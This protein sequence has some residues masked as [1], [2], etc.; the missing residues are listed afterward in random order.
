MHK[1]GNQLVCWMG[2][3]CGAQPIPTYCNKEMNIIK[4]QKE[5]LN[6]IKQKKEDDKQVGKL[7][8][9]DCGIEQEI[10]VHCGQAMHKEGDRL[11]CWMGAGC[12]AQP[13]PEHHGK[14]MEVIE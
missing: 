3:S 4:I 14:Q 2:A 1:E 13:I 5:E 11:V 6:S 10:P 7:K 9:V 8:C 12:G